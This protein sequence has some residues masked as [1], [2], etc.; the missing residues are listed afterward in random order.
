MKQI[1]PLLY[2]LVL[3][4]TCPPL[5][6][7]QFQQLIPG[8]EYGT[9]SPPTLKIN[10]HLL[11]IDL[12]QLQLI[13][14]D[15]RQLGRTAMTVKEMGRETGAL[16]VINANFFNGLNKPL[17]LVLKEGKILNPF[18]PTRWWASFLTKGAQAK[19]LKAFEKTQI[20]GFENGIQAGPRLVVAGR[21]PKLK[22]KSSPKSAIGIDAKGRVL[23]LVSQENVE[24]NSFARILA[25]PLK[26]G[27]LGLKHALNLDGGS[28][29]QFYL[30]AGSKEV[31]LPGLSK[32]PVGLGVFPKS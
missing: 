12:T 14:I 26:E 18:H 5:H 9:W 3:F 1:R 2:F 31:W 10:L 4:W 8:L 25:T 27:G 23:L 20:R 22:E 16:A 24:I 13:P 17:G 7:Q 15:G 30:K 29:T 11:R 32:V 6:A 21:S 28:S 19:I